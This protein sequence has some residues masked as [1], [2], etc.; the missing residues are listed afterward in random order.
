V[1]PTKAF[2]TSSTYRR[3]TF[4]SPICSRSFLMSRSHQWG[5]H[6][7][8][9]C[10]CRVTASTLEYVKRYGNVK[11]VEESAL[12]QHLGDMRKSVPA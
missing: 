7:R 10:H 2:R 1:V 6:A 9:S 5:S 11:A 8:M 12:P 4:A 3:Q